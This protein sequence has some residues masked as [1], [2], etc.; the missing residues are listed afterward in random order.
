M[1][2]KKA[3]QHREEGFCEVIFGARDSLEE[4]KNDLENLKKNFPE[5][6]EPE[7]YKKAL[8]MLGTLGSSS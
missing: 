7:F 5:L 4:L 6:I 8:E 1:F 2:N 3:R